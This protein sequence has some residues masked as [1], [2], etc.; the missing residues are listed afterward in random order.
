M[1]GSSI[2]VI[3]L[4]IGIIWATRIWKKSGTLNF[5]SRINASPELDHKDLKNDK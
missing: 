2:A 1:G 4:V 3:G 5:M